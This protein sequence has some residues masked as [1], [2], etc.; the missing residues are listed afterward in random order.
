MKCPLG[1][2]TFDKIRRNDYLYIDK[3]ALIHDLISQGEVYFLSRTA[4]LENPY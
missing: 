2:Q 1:I 4:V 3:A